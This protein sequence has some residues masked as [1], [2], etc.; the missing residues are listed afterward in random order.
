[1]SVFATE[2]VTPKPS[3]NFPPPRHI[4]QYGFHCFLLLFPVFVTFVWFRFDSCMCCFRLLFFQT[5]Y[6]FCLQY[7]DRPLLSLIRWTKHPETFRLSLYCSLYRWQII[8]CFSRVLFVCVSVHCFQLSTRTNSNTRYHYLAD[9]PINKRQHTHTNQCSKTARLLFKTQ[10]SFSVPTPK[11]G[12]GKS[13]GISDRQKVSSIV[14]LPIVSF[15]LSFTHTLWSYWITSFSFCV[16]VY[17]LQIFFST[18]STTISATS[19]LLFQLIFLLS[20]WCL[21]VCIHRLNPF[22]YTSL[23][24]SVRH[25]L[26]VV[27][28]GAWVC[29][30]TTVYVNNSTNFGQKPKRKRFCKSQQLPKSQS[31]RV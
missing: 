26:F 8:M 13:A 22:V 27:L 9:I 5:R 19:N 6:N 20:H 7:D 24:V 16:R 2:P 21:C 29:V 25:L 11:Q 30:C 4:Q 31:R 10:R 12:Q 14:F 1:M 17:F 28:I 18:H 3:R 23:T 15:S